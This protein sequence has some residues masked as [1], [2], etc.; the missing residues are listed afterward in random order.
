MSGFDIRISGNVAHITR[1]L[2]FA[3]IHK[4]FEF[5]QENCLQCTKLYCG[6][7]QLI[8]LPESVGNLASLELLDC[9]ANRFTSLP[10][11]IGNLKSLKILYC[12]YNDH[13]T[14]LPE[15]IGNLSSLK[16]LYCGYSQ[17]SSLPENIG[18]LSSIRTL[19]FLENRLTSLPESIVNLSSLESLVCKGNNFRRPT[20]AVREFLNTLLY[21][22]FIVTHPCESEEDWERVKR[23]EV[24]STFGGE[25][26]ICKGTFDEE[27][28]EVLSLSCFESHC[29]CR[30][31]Y[32]SWFNSQRDRS[33]PM[34]KRYF[35][36]D[37]CTL[38]VHT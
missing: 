1:G 31:C 24:P 11:E 5:L 2:K 34:C 10:E 35:V 7:I 27:C 25:C 12:G 18:N 23:V 19:S 28:R 4:C 3:T 6:E 33:C 17:I 13:L 32:E 20:L 26:M 21:C 9:S 15:S 8:T 29:V 30:E 16:A 37:E 22:N 36:F 38:F 14:S